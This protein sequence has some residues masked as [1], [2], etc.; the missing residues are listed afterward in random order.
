[1]ILLPFPA[2]KYAP[3]WNVIPDMPRADKTL[4]DVPFS[5]VTVNDVNTVSA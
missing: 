2:G 5:W 1:V 4:V 3:C